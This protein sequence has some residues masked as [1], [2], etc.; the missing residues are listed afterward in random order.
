M[1]SI[2]SIFWGEKYFVC[3]PATIVAFAHFKIKIDEFGPYEQ[4][5]HC[6]FN[7]QYKTI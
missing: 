2:Y 7:D 3:E 4:Q 5:L 1:W 6:F